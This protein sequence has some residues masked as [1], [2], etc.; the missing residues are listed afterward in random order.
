M[1]EHTLL[2]AALVLRGGLFCLNFNKAANLR[3]TI[4]NNAV[5]QRSSCFGHLLVLTW[6]ISQI[7]D[8]I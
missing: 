2:I 7:N 4:F 5:S 3:L 1:E 6:E 8:V